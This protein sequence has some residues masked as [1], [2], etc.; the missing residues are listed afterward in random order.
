MRWRS[1]RDRAVLFIHHVGTTEG[2]RNTR[3]RNNRA[4][5]RRAA[6]VR[7]A[8]LRAH[9]AAL[10]MSGKGTLKKVR[11]RLAETLRRQADAV[12]FG[13]LS[14]FGSSVARAIFGRFDADTDEASLNPLSHSRHG[15]AGEGIARAWRAQR[16]DLAPSAQP[17]ASSHF[18]SRHGT[19]RRRDRDGTTSA[20]DGSRPFGTAAESKFELSL[21]TRTSRRV[22]MARL[23]QQTDLAKSRRRVA[24]LAKSRRRESSLLHLRFLFDADR[25]TRRSRS[26][27]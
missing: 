18:H 10:G 15:R 8:Q 1:R 5:A 11:K 16:A 26:R 6:P 22:A 23:A 27:R 21:S 25:V 19:S 4:T 12:G 17:R 20:A 13:E 7:V 9:L 3:H 24:D 14:A 2:S